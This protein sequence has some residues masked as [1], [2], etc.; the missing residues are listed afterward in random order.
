MVFE[1]SV[2]T[3]HVWARGLSCETPVALGPPGLHTTTREPKRAHFRGPGASN[4]TKI[5]RKDPQERERRMKIVA[6]EGNKSAKFWAPPPP[7]TAP[8]FVVPKFNIQK[9][10]KV[11]I[12]R[13]QSRS[14][15]KPDRIRTI[16]DLLS[17]KLSTMAGIQL[18][19]GKTRTWN[20][21][22][23]ALRR[24]AELGPSVLQ[25]AVQNSFSGCAR[26]ALPR[27]NNC[28]KPLGRRRR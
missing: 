2:P 13:S 7:F 19:T 1:A 10:A 22:G 25:L 21:A 12:G 3:V 26:N 8:S 15:A 27:R 20:K 16:Y 24:M 28:G 23:V 14:M 11:E 6:G 9:F 4:T 18:H 5:P 17:V